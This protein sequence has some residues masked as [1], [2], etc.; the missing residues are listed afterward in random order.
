PF[1]AVV[2]KS[3]AVTKS[4]FPAPPTLFLTRQI[5][6]SAIETGVSKYGSSNPLP[7]FLLLSS[8]LGYAL[9]RSSS[10]PLALMLYGSRNATVRGTPSA[11]EVPQPP[12]QL[13]PFK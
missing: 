6:V 10:V 2:S 7:G 11:S 3:P 8:S 5:P 9:A 1:P 4:N 12:S 13:A